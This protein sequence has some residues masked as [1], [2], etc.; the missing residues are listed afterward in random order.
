MNL[1]EQIKCFLE[2]EIEVYGDELA[3]E[4]EVT[5]PAP[6][7]AAAPGESEVNGQRPS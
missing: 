2:Q 1:Y 5:E 6:P 3:V 4:K 7:G